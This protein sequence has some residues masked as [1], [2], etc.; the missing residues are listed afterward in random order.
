MEL[1]N[2]EQVVAIIDNEL[3][4]NCGKCYMTCNDSGYQSIKFDKD[5]HLPSVTDECTGCTLCLSVCPIPECISM[6]P[7]KIP[8]I[9]IRG[10]PPGTE[11]SFEENKL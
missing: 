1:N 9:P 5:T 4:I 3:C 11:V 10:L 7:R 6:V 8:Y 2:K